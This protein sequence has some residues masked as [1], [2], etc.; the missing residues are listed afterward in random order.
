MNFNKTEVKKIPWKGVK[1]LSAGQQRG[2]KRSSADL[3]LDGLGLKAGANLPVSRRILGFGELL[4][5]YFSVEN[6]PRKL[7]RVKQFSVEY[8]NSSAF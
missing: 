3:C 4:M 5:E 7:L 1:K 2:S 6:L 8:E